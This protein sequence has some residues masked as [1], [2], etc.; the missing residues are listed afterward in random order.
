MLSAQEGEMVHWGWLVAA[1]FGGTW[2]GVLLMAVLAAASRADEDMERMG[3]VMQ[4]MER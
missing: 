2:A 3:Q 4:E 1:A